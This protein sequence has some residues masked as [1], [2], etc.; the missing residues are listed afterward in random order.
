V[1]S[2]FV[3]PAKAEGSWA[4]YFETWRA[5]TAPERSGWFELAAPWNTR[6]A[7]TLDRSTFSAWGP[8]LER[9]VGAGRTLILCGVA[10]DCCVVATALAAVDDGVSVRVVADA[11][12]GATAEAHRRALDLMLG[13]APQIEVTDVDDER[14]RAGARA[15]VR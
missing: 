15:G 13:F 5:V 4:R 1:F 2:R 9:L 7:S 6:A 8:E 12:R 10:T 11:C 3:L 14:R